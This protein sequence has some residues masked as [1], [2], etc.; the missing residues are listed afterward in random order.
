MGYAGK[1]GIQDDD[2][3]FR[4]EVKKDGEREGG[5]IEG[6]QGEQRRREGD[7]EGTR[8]CRKRR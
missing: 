1:G 6:R 5:E 8:V 4:K 7:E 2:R 3:G